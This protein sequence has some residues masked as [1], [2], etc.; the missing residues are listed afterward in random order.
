MPYFFISLIIHAAI[1]LSVFSYAN[2]SF[3]KMIPGDSDHQ[4][5]DA[6]VYQNASITKIRNEKPNARQGI[7]LNSQISPT[8][9][10]Q[11]SQPHQSRAANKGEK[12]SGLLAL[13]HNAI[14]NHQHYPES[15]LQ[16]E[17]EGRVTV[18]FI[19]LTDGKIRQPTIVQS[20][21]TSSLDLAALSAIEAATPF[22]GI[23]KYI[24]Q[25]GEYSI[26]VVFQMS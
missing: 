4:S 12:E 10:Q 2:N 9:T 19:L 1:L 20:S 16:M 26:D 15:A 11:T 7:A 17:R 13:L 5:I 22:I 23:D 14:Q 8:V 21:G 25:D 24:Q 6:Y 3:T 18:K